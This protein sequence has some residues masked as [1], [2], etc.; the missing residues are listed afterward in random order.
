MRT[1]AL[2]TVL[3]FMMTAAAEVVPAVRR[4][5]AEIHF[6]SRQSANPLL[7]KRQFCDIS[8]PYTCSAIDGD[9][10]CM[11]AN[12]VCCQRIGSDGTFPFV[13]DAAH[14]YCCPSDNG[15]PQC[16]SDD[17]C[18]GNLDTAPTQA[19]ATES[20]GVS[21]QTATAAGGPSK[22]TT[23]PKKT[24]AAEHVRAM[25]GGAMAVAMLGMMAA[26]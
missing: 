11:S 23:A 13:C 5:V 3:V 1:Y 22:A 9:A 8:Y 16:G 17:T 18:G 10:M 21:P 6:D 14:P 12:E 4:N 20:T 24:N 2:A 26:L 15:I 25:D 7:G 19:L